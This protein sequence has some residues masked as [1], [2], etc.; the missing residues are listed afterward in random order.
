MSEQT[1]SRPEFRNLNL[2]RDVA[3]YRLP[4]AG[5]ASILHRASGAFLCLLLP[6]AIWLFD[7]SLTSESSFAAFSAALDNGFV[8]FVAWL[9]L[10]A[11][12]LH[13]FGGLRHLVLDVTHRMTKP[14]GRN[15]ALAVFIATAV[16]AV[17]FGIMMM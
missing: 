16:L 14:F 15:T 2:F 11:Y 7:K 12:L 4:P 3:R 8:R 9:L 1:K 6:F 17:V 10:V 5:W 13:L